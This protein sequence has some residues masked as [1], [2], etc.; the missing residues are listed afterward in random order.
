MIKCNVTV[1]GTI[2]RVATVR[3]NNE[4]KVFTAFAVNLCNTSQKLH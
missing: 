1:G 2:S 4:G 3:T